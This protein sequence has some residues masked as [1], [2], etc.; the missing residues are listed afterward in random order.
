MF[1]N[2]EIEVRFN[3][4]IYGKN[5]K[6]ICDVY[7]IISAKKTEKSWWKKMKA[8]YDILTKKNLKIKGSTIK[9]CPGIFDFTN[10]GYIIPAWQDFRFWVDDDGQIE[11]Q[12]PITMQPI[13]NIN[14]HIQE[15]IDTCPIL[16][17]SAQ[18]ILKLT[19]PW[20]IS[21]PKGTS[22]IICKPFYHYSN[23]FDICPGV[24]DS[25]MESLLPNN[26]I[27]AM[28]RFNVKNKEIYIK[29]GQPLIQL[30]PFKRTNWKLKHLEI[31]KNFKDKVNKND[32][33]M[34]TRFE[35]RVIDKDSMSKS[36]QDDSNKKFE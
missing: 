21:T 20:L 18:Y 32:I 22:L 29:A 15:Q 13:N 9:Y 19:S 12:E 8:Q 2:N 17:D 4:F 5:L 23:D 28:I 14:A 1:N 10:Y 3:E 30:I 6:N 36:R 27:N 26:T 25:D 24:L 35:G 11:I 16:D 7:P 34:N 33:K 31:D